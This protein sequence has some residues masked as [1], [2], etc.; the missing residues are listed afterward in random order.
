MRRPF[1]PI[2]GKTYRN[3]GGGNYRCISSYS[4]YE[5]CM[6]NVDSGWTFT[7]IGIGQY[8]D[9]TIDWDRS[10]DGRFDKGGVDESGNCH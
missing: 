3:E 2:A 1:T 5:A 6:V 4:E 9:G 8:S 10:L 7:A